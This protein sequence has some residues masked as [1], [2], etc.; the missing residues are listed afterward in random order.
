MKVQVDARYPDPYAVQA[1]AP[2]GPAQVAPAPTAPA[3]VVPAPVAVDQYAHLPENLR[4]N[5][6]P[7]VAMARQA[8]DLIAQRTDF[9]EARYQILDVDSDDE[10][11]MFPEIP[12]R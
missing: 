4:P 2:Q 1:N 6:D 11:E 5:T 3:P 9:S 12:R 8:L 7:L 10:S